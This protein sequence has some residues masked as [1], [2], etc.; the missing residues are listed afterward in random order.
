MENASLDSNQALLA[1]NADYN[2]QWIRGEAS[3]L[4]LLNALLLSETRRKLF[5]GWRT[6]AMA[7]VSSC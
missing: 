3:V 1:F 5:R 2:T 7:I 6:L 4:D